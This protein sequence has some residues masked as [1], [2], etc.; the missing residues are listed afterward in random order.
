MG[1]SNIS[2][3]EPCSTCRS[4]AISSNIF[5]LRATKDAN[6]SAARLISGSAGGGGGGADACARVATMCQ[7]GDD[8][9][10]LGARP[11]A[12]GRVGVTFGPLGAGA[13]IVL[14]SGPANL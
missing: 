1:S 13:G 12:M 5:P 8:A 11:T 9:V 4:L 10:P 3:H 6:V 14:K 7:V 2:P